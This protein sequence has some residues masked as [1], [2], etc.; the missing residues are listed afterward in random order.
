MSICSIRT[1]HL[2]VENA[3]PK[4]STYANTQTHYFTTCTIPRP[5]C[6]FSHAKERKR[7]GHEIHQTE[8]NKVGADPTPRRQ[9]LAKN[10]EGWGLLSLIQQLPKFG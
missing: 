5:D 2:D 3:G 1:G 4:C 7:N 8:G 6:D 10:V 9:I